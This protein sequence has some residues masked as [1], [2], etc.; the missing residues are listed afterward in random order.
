M[1]DANQVRDSKG[2][3]LNPGQNDSE[4]WQTV[5]LASSAEI[6]AEESGKVV[7]LTDF[8]GSGG[9]A[10]AGLCNVRKKDA[11]GTIIFS[12]RAANA[13][14]DAF[15]SF[16]EGIEGDAYDGAGAGSLYCQISGN[17]VVTFTGYMR[18]A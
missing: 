9:A 12:F 15:G 4:H 7:V 11:S 5:R 2:K 14:H 17:I 13:L 16:R 18:D 8:V 1:T 3:V 10:T 6:K